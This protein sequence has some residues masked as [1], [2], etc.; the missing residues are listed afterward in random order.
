M[1]ELISKKDLLIKANISYGQL[2]RW[3]RKNIIPEEWFIKKSTFTGQE[4]F[5]PKEKILERIDLILSMKDDASLDDIAN[6]FNKKNSEK[7]FSIDIMIEKNIISNH[8]KEVFY[9]LYEN[10][11]VIGRKELLIITIIEKYLLKSV[12]T[13]E[14]MKIVIEII[15]KDFEKLYKDDARLYVFRKFGVPFVIGCIDYRQVITSNELVKVM[16]IDLIKEISDITK[17]IIC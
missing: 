13:M 15:N 12:I 10:S 14:E 8:A 9:S 6:M 16:E 11:E 2:Y 17:L 5:F 3:K 1:E 7:E 4:T